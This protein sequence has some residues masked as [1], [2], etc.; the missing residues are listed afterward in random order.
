MKT[1]ESK[2]LPVPKIKAIL[3]SQFVTI[4]AFP[5]VSLSVPRDWQ[6][7]DSKETQQLVT[8]SEAVYGIG[9]G[10]SKTENVRVFQPPTAVE[11]VSIAVISMPVTLPQQVWRTAND[12][13]LHEWASVFTQ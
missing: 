9:Q 5:G 7:V 13:Q 2:I 12:A 8:A 1:M 3:E 11:G 4:E 6:V 10:I